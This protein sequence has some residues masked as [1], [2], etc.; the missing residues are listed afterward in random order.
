MRNGSKLCLDPQ[1]IE[2]LTTT[3]SGRALLDV[4]LA[5]AGDTQGGAVKGKAD[6]LANAYCI[7]L[8][9]MKMTLLLF[10]GLHIWRS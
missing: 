1:Y 5:S 7:G 6:E 3:H 8:N 9:A 4:V 2:I 10:L